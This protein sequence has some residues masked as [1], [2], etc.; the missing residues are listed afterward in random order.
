MFKDSATGVSQK[1]AFSLRYYVGENAVGEPL[2]K[3]NSTGLMQLDRRIESGVYS[4]AVNGGADSGS[5][6]SQKSYRYGEVN[7]KR[8]K[9]K[10]NNDSAE[11]LL[12]YE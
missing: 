11:F 1:F 12:V 2:G 3:T 5:G 4:F 6:P 10:V 9:K 7:L 8:S